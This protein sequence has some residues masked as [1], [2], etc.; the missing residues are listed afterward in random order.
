MGRGRRIQSVTLEQGMVMIEI[1]VIMCHGER[2][3]YIVH[4]DRVVSM[5]IRHDHVYLITIT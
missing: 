3:S 1:A 4:R 5:R 2:L